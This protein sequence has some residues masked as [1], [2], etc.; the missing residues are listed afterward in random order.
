MKHRT[1]TLAAAFAIFAAPQIAVAMDTLKLAV[2]QR[3]AWPT[4]ISEVGV[5]AGFFKKRDLT[6]E[7]TYTAGGGET[8]QPVISGAVDIGVGVGTS[9]AIGAFAKG[10]PVRIIG[11]NTTG[12]GDLMWFVRSDS[13]IKTMKDVNG[14]TFAYGSTGSST[15]IVGRALLKQFDVDAKMVA[16][17]NMA[18]T[19]TAT[20]SGQVDVGWTSAPYVFD[21]LNAGRIRIIVTGADAKEYVDQTVR[22][23]AANADSL[24]T[25]ADAIRRYVDGYRETL[26]WMY[27]D[28][29][30]AIATVAAFMGQSEKIAGQTRGIYPKATIDFDRI[31]GLDGVM[32]DAVEGK[33][34][35]APLT[36]QQLKEVIVRIPAR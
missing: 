1:A 20:L 5:R 19:T 2:G 13:P 8:L 29:P 9:A 24:K 36:A 21:L 22:V 27:S 11:G 7:I 16:L 17:G 18:A 6:L 31:T 3:G 30:A 4:S 15:Q 28:D 35:S 32:E 25:K 14:H 23:I 34:M 26:N 12:A 10:A 33:L